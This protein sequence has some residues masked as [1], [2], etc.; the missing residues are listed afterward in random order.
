MNSIM[1]LISTKICKTSD[2]GIHNNLFGGTMLS[3]MD[4]AAGTMAAEMACTPNMI[5]LKMDEV[6]FKKPVKVSDHI[7][8]YGELLH[9]GTSSLTLS[10]I[11]KKFCFKKQAEETV[12]STKMHFVNIDENG[13]SHAI[14]ASIRE[15]LR[16]LI[17]QHN[18]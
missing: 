18:F 8:I 10:I 7:R 13:R 9:V 15:N 16:H 12:C 14:D 4:E 11:A 6:L 2:I 1:Q 5:T 17:N 3:W